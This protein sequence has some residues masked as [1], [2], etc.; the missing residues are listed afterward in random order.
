MQRGFQRAVFSESTAAQHEVVAVPRVGKRI[1]IRGG[2][3]TAAAAQDAIIQSAN[4]TL[5]IVRFSDS[6]ALILP[7]TEG[8][9]AEEWDNCNV[10]EALNITLGQA[11]QTDGVIF[12]DVL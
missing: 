8:G 11:V 7:F 4:N 2:F 1:R 6:F 10:D 3:L 9:T 5:S 12:Y